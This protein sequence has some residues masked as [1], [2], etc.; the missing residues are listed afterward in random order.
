MNVLD[1][2]SAYERIDPGG[3]PA[4]QAGTRT[5]IRDLPRQCRAAWLEAQALD[6]PPD[7]RDVEKV[8]ILGMGG[9]VIAGDLLRSLVALES[10]VPVF[11]HRDYG[12]PL[13][14][15][16]R[17]LLIAMS[18]TGDTEETVSGF[19][20]GL[21]TGAKK[22]V[23]TTGG[24]LLALA[25]ANGVPAF[26]FNYKSTVRGALG[27]GL[28]PLLA[29]AGKA[30]IVA[31]KAGDVEEAAVVMEGMAGRIGE[32]VPLARN[33]AKQLAE[34]LEG[35]LPVIYGAGILLEVAFRWK[36]QL[37][38]NSKLWA[39]CEELP[40]ANHNAIV[41]FG[42]P[43]EIAARTFAVFLQAPALHP[44]IRLRY[45]FTRRT[46]AEAGVPSEAVDAEGKS[47]LAQVMSSVLFGDYVSLYLAILAGVDPS[48]TTVIADLK[49]WLADRP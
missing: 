24:R 18:Y 35:R 45:E 25:R 47:P 40:E 29:I 32:D 33:P 11:V 7:Y 3:L 48:P 12:L 41:G 14:V 13:L 22:L 49:R 9:L 15:D 10:P 31:D 20:A 4:G 42:L 8:V 21:S 6:L 38:E 1:D 27:Y 5:L 44:R 39:L 26:V 16:D 36:T 43:R 28:M 2:P 30:G 46:L 23:I 37:N 19:E 34:K 17:T